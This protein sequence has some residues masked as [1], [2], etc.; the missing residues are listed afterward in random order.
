MF[1]LT[2]ALSRGRIFDETLP[3]LAAAGIAPEDDPEASR[4]LILASNRADLR[5]VIVRASDVPTYVQHGAADLGSPEGRAA[6]ARRRGLYRS[7]WRSAAAAWSSRRAGISITPAPYSAA[8][9]SRSPPSTS[10]RRESISAPREF[11]SI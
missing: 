3:L 2:I 10:A 5:F 11:M 9:G 6:G 4:K 7:T 1:P 8:P